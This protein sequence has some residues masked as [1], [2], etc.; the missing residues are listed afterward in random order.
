MKLDNIGEGACPVCAA[1]MDLHE[2]DH[3]RCPNGHGC[4][5]ATTDEV[6]VVIHVRDS[7]SPQVEP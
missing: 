7:F 5:S 2:D 3:G 4:Y 6:T 1:V